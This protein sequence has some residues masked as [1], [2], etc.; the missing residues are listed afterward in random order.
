MF[1]TDCL[2][3]FESTNIYHL[4]KQFGDQGIVVHTF[5]TST[6]DVE[7]DG[8][9]RVHSQLGL[10]YMVQDIQSYIGRLSVK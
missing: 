7:A 8:V 4:S 1:H 3:Q 6:G 5:N 10:L 9:L 2:P